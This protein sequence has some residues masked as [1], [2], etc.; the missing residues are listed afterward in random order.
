MRK[1]LVWI[2]AAALVV[3]VSV[4]GIASIASASDSTGADFS[5]LKMKVKPTKLKKKKF[6]GVKLFVETSTLDNANPGTPTSPGNVPVATNDV[7]L[8]FDKDLKFTSKGLAQCDAN[9]ISQ[10]TTQQALSICGKAKVGGGSATA[11]I[12]AAGQP[13]TAH[14]PFVVTAF[15]GKKQG[16]KSQIVLHSR[17][18]SLNLTTTLIGTLNP[19]SNVLDVPVPAL[20]ATIT[21]FKTTV[22]KGFK[23]KGKKHNYAAAKCSHKKLTVKGTFSYVNGDPADHPTASAKCKGK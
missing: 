20:P 13:C 12:G 6:K 8:K 2:S 22:K 23:V 7:K 14:V 4:A 11:C 9:K 5:Q 18:D 1:H 19:K 10:A 17:N 15:N 21:D 16:K 3:A